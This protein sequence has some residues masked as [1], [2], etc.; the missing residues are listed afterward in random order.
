MYQATLFMPSTVH[1]CIAWLSDV[2]CADI[3]ELYR[4]RWGDP[5][6]SGGRAK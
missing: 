4:V 5:V 1:V 6:V 3:E 2:E